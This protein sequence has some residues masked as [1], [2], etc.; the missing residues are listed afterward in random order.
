MADLGNWK[1]SPNY[2][3]ADVVGFGYHTQSSFQCQLSV[4]ILYQDTSLQ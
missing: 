4:L 1:D 3:K 2:G